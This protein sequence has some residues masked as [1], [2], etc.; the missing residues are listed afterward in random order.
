MSEHRS[1]N[2]AQNIT[3]LSSLQD[4]FTFQF[5]Q[6][7]PIT[8]II[9]AILWSIGLPILLYELLKPR[10]GQVVA[11]IIASCPPL[12]IVISRMLKTRKLDVLGFVAGISFLISGIIS[13]AQPSPQ[14]SSICES[15]V[16]LL[17][18]VF[19]LISLL[20]IKIGK[21]EL[22]PLVFEV[23]SQLMPRTERNEELS[24]K[25][26]QRLHNP[27]N[28]ENKGGL[29][30]WV[31]GHMAKVRNDLRILTA[32]WGIVLVVGFIVKAI[33]ASTS[34]DVSKAQH[35]GHPGYDGC[36]FYVYETNEKTC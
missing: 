23:T 14:V 33:I 10:L 17:V 21:F 13:I 22:R 6:G 2:E 26:K 12:V 18:G 15:I 35:F 5:V 29:L 7:R 24:A 16:P 4:I 1:T 34:T 36:I 20:P 32:C 19:C 9:M 27:R 31:Y 11:M 8:N 3:D 28:A 30:D 25:D